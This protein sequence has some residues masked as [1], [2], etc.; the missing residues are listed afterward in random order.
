MSHDLR[1]RGGAATAS[2]DTDVVSWTDADRLD[3][4][5][6]GHPN[7]RTASHCFDAD[8]ACLLIRRSWL[9]GI[10]RLSGSLNARAGSGAGVD[11]GDARSDHRGYGG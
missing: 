2:S 4:G 3:H 7:G 1:V 10:G 8:R 5:G 6:P 11:D 9:R